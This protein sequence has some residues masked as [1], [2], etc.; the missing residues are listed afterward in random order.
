MADFY[1]VGGTS[2][3]S[4]TLSNWVTTLGGA[5]NP[6]LAI[7]NADYIYFTHYGV[8]DCEMVNGTVAH[9]I[10]WISVYDEEVTYGTANREIGK[11][12]RF[13]HKLYL[14]GS[15]DTRGLHL[16]GEIV[17][18]ATPTHTVSLTLSGSTMTSADGRA[19]PITFGKYGVL[20][21][22]LSLNIFLSGV[23]FL[24]PA[25]YP[26][27]V[28]T[29]GDWKTNYAKPTAVAS[30]EISF[31]SLDVQAGAT[32]SVSEPLKRMDRRM[33]ISFRSNAGPTN[34]LSSIQ[35]LDF[36]YATIKQA[37]VTGA[38]QYLIHSGS[39]YSGHNSGDIEVKY[40]GYHLWYNQNSSTKPFWWDI[41]SLIIWSI[42]DLTV[43]SNC[44]IQGGT[45]SEIHC[46]SLP[47]VKG[48]LGNF[49]QIN[50]G[51]Y[52]SSPNNI[53]SD[54]VISFQYGGTGLTALGTANQVLAT[55]AAATAIEWQTVSGGGGSGTVT[56]VAL[57]VPTGLVITGSPITTTGTLA[58]SY[59]TGY[60]IPTTA[61]QTEWDSAYGWGD[62]ASASY[63]TGAQG[64][65]ADTAHTWG[66]H[67]V[68]GYL[69][70]GSAQL[71]AFS[72][73][74]PGLWIAPPPATIQDAIERIAVAIS[75]LSGP[76]P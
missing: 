54:P 38:L 73:T 30:T 50:S 57:S 29:T 22:E 62:H 24:E 52:R 59:T 40:H 53:L 45:S 46:V 35:S 5:T 56:S 72:P 7:T 74:N 10:S 14:K 26:I 17:A 61:K 58:I 64:T 28:I 25:N 18:S 34:F 21:D 15:L 6:T 11:E 48:S 9:E 55:N 60:A 19:V 2:T 31:H 67:A 8:R 27:T 4:A 75:L 44:I 3:D 37:G 68:A 1:W 41:D 49:L 43:D 42:N 20:D 71:D 51:R 32:V 69:L 13:L 63:A 39:S 47:K 70:P 23:F 66:N 12:N 16:D 36:G 76:I 33:V 65:K